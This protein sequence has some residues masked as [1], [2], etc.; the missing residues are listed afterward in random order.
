M[1]ALDALGMD[2]GQMM[3]ARIDDGGGGSS[4]SSGGNMQ[5]ETLEGARK[6]KTRF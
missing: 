2:P 1:A 4:S 6:R 3:L 5:L